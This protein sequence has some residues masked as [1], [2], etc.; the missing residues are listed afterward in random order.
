MTGH[1]RWTKVTIVNFPKKFPRLICL[2][3]YATLYFVI[4]FNGFFETLY[5]YDGV[6][7]VDKVNVSFF[8]KKYLFRSNEAFQHDGMQQVDEGNVVKFS[9]KTLYQC[10]WAIWVQFGSKLCNLMFQLIL[11]YDLLSENFEMLQYDEIQQLD[12][13]NVS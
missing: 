3:N 5:Y 7:Q 4:F 8:S 12:Q 6:H 1:N 10:N 13:S 9:P 2:K 11:S